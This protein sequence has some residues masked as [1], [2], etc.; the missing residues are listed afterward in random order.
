MHLL[1][2][3]ERIVVLDVGWIGGS[4]GVV[5]EHGRERGRCDTEESGGKREEKERRLGV[6]IGRS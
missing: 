3:K 1:K 2:A 5:F 4:E 6:N